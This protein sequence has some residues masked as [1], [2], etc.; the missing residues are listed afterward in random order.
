M[1]FAAAKL[2]ERVQSGFKKKINKR[3]EMEGVS[4]ENGF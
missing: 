3:R 4:P 2:T 1:M